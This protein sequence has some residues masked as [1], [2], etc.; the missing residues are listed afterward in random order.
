MVI[1]KR[2]KDKTTISETIQ[3]EIIEHFKEKGISSKE[4]YDSTYK[5][6]DTIF[7]NKIGQIY[8]YG[9]NLFIESNTFQF[10]EILKE[11]EKQ[12]SIDYENIDIKI[13]IEEKWYKKS[14]KEEFPHMCHC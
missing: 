13:S 3:K 9:G 14:Q 12:L 8:A 2:T 4:K 10:S 5:K 11:I 6:T 1:I 7:G